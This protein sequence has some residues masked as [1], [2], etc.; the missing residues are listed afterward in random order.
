MNVKDLIL[1]E[2]PESTDEPTAITKP[3]KPRKAPQGPTWEVV[4][5]DACDGAVRR[6]TA[7]TSRLLV[8]LLSQ[9]QYYIK[10]EVADEVEELNANNLAAFLKGCSDGVKPVPWS[11]TLVPGSTHAERFVRAINND[12]FVWL[13]KRG[14]HTLCY[15]SSLYQD[16]AYS[17]SSERQK[18]DSPLRKAII[19]VCTEVVG[20]E[21]L[22]NVMR[23][24]CAN[25]QERKA[26]SCIDRQHDI[27][28][29]YEKFGLDWTR[30][31]VRAF[32]TS[33]F[34]GTYPVESYRL[35]DLLNG[36]NY[37][38]SRFIEYLFHDSVA[39]GY[40]VVSDNVRARYYENLSSFVNQWDDTLQMQK[41]LRG[42]VYDKYP[43]SL[44]EMHQQLSFRMALY[45][46]RIDEFGF[47]DH[48][49]RLSKLSYQDDKYLI[50]PPYNKADMCD[51]A[52]QQANCLATYVRAY[53]LNDTDIYFMRSVDEPEKSLVTVEV[54]DAKVRQA[55]RAYNRQPSDE[56]LEWLKSWCANNNI[57]WFDADHQRPLCA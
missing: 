19:A 35:S 32:L 52:S 40:G 7:K 51:E 10:D 29:F 42:K 47:K 6:K 12:D 13:A 34:V 18:Y 38:P 49:E 9:K 43:S 21:R 23:G 37:E 30:E 36:R 33:P 39:M 24:D 1:S 11:T 57:D 53:S 44:T 48:S 50:R 8:L 22:A 28:P 45:E 20:E 41:R 2:L 17:L 31:Y 54:R 14:L 3:R 16:G 55:Y 25:E 46:Q 5:T 27:E 26:F 4:L 15:E 56:E